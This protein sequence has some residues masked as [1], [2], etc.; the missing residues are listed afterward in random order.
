LFTLYNCSC[1][2]IELYILQ[3]MCYTQDDLTHGYGSNVLY[4]SYVQV[5]GKMYIN[6]SPFP[7]FKVCVKSVHRVCMRE[8][9][10]LWKAS[11]YVVW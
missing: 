5:S 11:Y 10:K 3:I 7:G 8:F 9:I 4:D 6:K 1:L 2:K